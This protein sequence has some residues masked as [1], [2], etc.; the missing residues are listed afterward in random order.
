MIS[1]FNKYFFK[2][3]I[4]IT[5]I[6]LLILLTIASAI[7]LT[8][9]LPE[10]ASQTLIQKDILVVFSLG[11]IKFSLLGIPIIFAL[12]IV[13]VM[14]Q[15]TQ[16]QEQLAATTIGLSSK[17]QLSWS[18]TWGL[19]ASILCSVL[20]TLAPKQ[21][22]KIQQTQQKN[23]YTN[24]INLPAYTIQNINNNT[25]I[26][27]TKPIL[28][29]NYTNILLL[30]INNTSPLT[31]KL[32]QANR[33]TYQETTKEKTWQLQD[34]KIFKINNNNLQTI[35]FGKLNYIT[36]KQTINNKPSLT[37]KTIGQLLNSNSI[38]SNIELQQRF[39]PIT[40]SIVLSILA[41]TTF[42][43][44]IR[45]SQWKKTL[46]LLIL[47]ILYIS[48]LKISSAYY[49]K[50]GDINKTWLLYCPHFIML[51]ISCISTYTKVK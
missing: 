50:N 6:T 8:E 18:L 35:E 49:L 25:I 38:N 4:K 36:K 12:A 51:F 15:L 30:T 48:L 43:S 34:G 47:I 14:I 3:L 22:L 10:I 31:M 20:T 9:T 2:K 23:S 46:P 1:Q 26:T 19:I 28:N 39:N 27:T 24:Q 41:F 13:L 29:S 32:W 40:M 37:N 16:T 7:I 21:S 42:S 17:K 33:A 5:S 44:K 11:I 45:Q